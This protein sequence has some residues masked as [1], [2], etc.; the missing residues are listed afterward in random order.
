MLLGDRAERL[1]VARVAE[2]VHGQDPARARRDGRLDGRRVEHER[3]GI[4]VGEHGRRPLVEHHVGRGDERDRRRDDLVAR[5]DAGR[6][7]QQVQPGRAARDGDG[8]LAAAEGRELLLEVARVR[9]EPED[10]GAQR[11]QDVLLLLRPDVG[12]RERY[13]ARRLDVHALAAVLAG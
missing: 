10:A 4:H 2:H 7:H 1:H 8:V 9:A 5:T 11:G 6:P 12:P 3:L 13:L